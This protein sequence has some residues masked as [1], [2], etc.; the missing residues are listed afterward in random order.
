[1]NNGATQQF[2]AAD[3]LCWSAAGTSSNN[4]ET[5]PT[6][7]TTYAYDE[8]GNRTVAVTAANTGTCEAYDQADRLTSITTGTGSACSSPAAVGTYAYNG[9]G[10]RMSK[11]VSE[12]TTQ[13]TWNESGELPLLLQE[14]TGNANAQDYIY[15][16]SGLPIE[17]VDGNGN[18]HFYHDNALGSTRAVTNSS[19]A[20]D[21]TYTYD[22]Y[23][24]IE[25]STD[26]GAIANPFLFAGEYRDGESGLY[27]LHAR[28]YDPFTG[29]F[30][31]ED[32]MVAI[33]GSPYGYVAG[34]PTNG[35]DPTGMWGLPDLNPVDWVKATAGGAVSL[36]HNAVQNIGQHC[37]V[38]FNPNCQEDF[39]ENADAL[40]SSPI[41]VVVGWDPFYGDLRDA[42]KQFGYGCSVNW[43]QDL[44]STAAIFAPGPG[45]ILAKTG[46]NANGD[47][48]VATYVGRLTGNY[49]L[50]S[51]LQS[52]SG[53]VDFIAG[54]ATQ[55]GVQTITGDPTA[56][57]S[58]CG[59][60]G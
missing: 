13:F 42:I 54:G 31:T 1:M 4:C 60:G 7:A 46:I 44:V 36:V 37:I 6:G 23:G 39:L 12:A 11:T 58:S 30:L 28:Y 24:N 48:L 59:C 2:N 22:P 15:G 14:Q 19:G 17:Q 55:S 35:S 34:N 47:M 52:N 10:L 3:E 38:L 25:S 41:G 49:D 32:P 51:G 27:Y 43:A 18:A 57:Q 5:P 40:D 29:Q 50:A 16:P 21:A 26:P 53:W 33:T 9:A 56:G 45:K 8:R 20:V